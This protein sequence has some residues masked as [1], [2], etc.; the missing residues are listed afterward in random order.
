MS[1]RQRLGLLSVLRAVEASRQAM[2]PGR[3]AIPAAE[4]PG[5]RPWASTLRFR[6][7]ELVQA[8]PDA[9][10]R[11]VPSF[12]VRFALASR[13]VPAHAVVARELVRPAQV[14]GA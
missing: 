5:Y 6:S 7:A 1:R 8:A 2:V 9:T 14:P 3:S 10:M 13:F 11:P 4:D 12:A